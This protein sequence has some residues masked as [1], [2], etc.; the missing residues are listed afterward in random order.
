MK[1]ELVSQNMLTAAVTALRRK[2]VAF[3]LEEKKKVEVC[4]LRTVA[5]KRINVRRDSRYRQ[6]TCSQG[7]QSLDWV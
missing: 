1:F 4:V 6:D 2:R 3:R 7:H 5:W